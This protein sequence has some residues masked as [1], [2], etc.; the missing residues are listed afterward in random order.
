MLHNNN[1][2]III[3]KKPMVI[4]LIPVHQMMIVCLQMTQIQKQ[5]NKFYKWR[6]TV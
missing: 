3:I 4:Y 1:N 5:M 6:K 2:K